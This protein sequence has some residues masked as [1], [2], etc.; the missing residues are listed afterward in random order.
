M[1]NS[2]P[3]SSRSWIPVRGG[4]AFLGL[5][6]VVTG[7]ADPVAVDDRYDATEDLVLNTQSGPIISVDFDTNSGGVVPV[8]DGDWDYL[9]ALENQIGANDS[10]PVDD[11]G[12]SWNSVDFEVGS[13]SIGPW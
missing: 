7:F 6:F 11:A 5:L 4:S 9:D 3:S 13:S 1:E 10:Y 12:R 2:N 8:F